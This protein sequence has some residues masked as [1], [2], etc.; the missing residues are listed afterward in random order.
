M[1]AALPP[2]QW[3]EQFTYT[4][5]RIGEDQPVRMVYTEVI[6]AAINYD[7]TAEHH[8]PAE[9]NTAA[10]RLNDLAARLEPATASTR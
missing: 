9:L 8:Q 2:E 7:F 10:A 1:I 6:A 5:N 3:D 4:A